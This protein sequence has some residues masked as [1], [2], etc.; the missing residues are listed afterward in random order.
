[1]P[2]L[3]LAAVAEQGG[4]E[5]EQEGAQHLVQAQ[6][7]DRALGAGTGGALRPAVGENIHLGS[8][9]HYHQP[10]QGYFS[11]TCGGR[12]GW[13]GKAGGGGWRP[14]RHM[15]GRKGPG[16][17]R[18]WGG[19]VADEPGAEGWEGKEARRRF[20]TETQRHG[21]ARQGRS[22]G[23]W[24]APWSLADAGCWHMLLA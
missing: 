9:F 10:V 7:P 2:G 1:M 18:V 14:R 23:V 15:G 11:L 17:R 20:T 21:E 16:R 19:G 8:L 4:E 6:V 5:G 12:V 13:A 22:G 3:G 24:H